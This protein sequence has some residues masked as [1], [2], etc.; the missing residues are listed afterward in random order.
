MNVM[1]VVKEAVRHLGFQFFEARRPDAPA[2]VDALVLIPT[3]GEVIHIEVKRRAAHEHATPQG[4]RRLVIYDPRDLPRLR[5]GTEAKTP[6]QAL[7]MTDV[8]ADRIEAAL[9]RLAAAA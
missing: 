8:T 2:A 9:Q 4:A 5:E 1:S 3:T 6:V 7:P